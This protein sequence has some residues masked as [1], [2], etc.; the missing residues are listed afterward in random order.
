MYYVLASTR[1]H[2]HST[3]QVQINSARTHT[4][5]L[6]VRTRVEYSTVLEYI[7]YC[8]RVFRF[9]RDALIFN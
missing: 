4:R 2:K 5:V 6:N 7:Q 3:V 8:T 1:A 9:I